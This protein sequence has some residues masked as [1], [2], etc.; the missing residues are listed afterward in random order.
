M[1]KNIEIKAR[2]SDPDQVEKIA[3]KLSGKA[4]RII[5]QEDVFFIVPKGRLKLRKFSPEEGELIFY[6][7]EN[8]IQP[9]ESHYQQSKTIDVKT[10]EEVLAKALGIRGVVRKIRKLFIVD[11]TRIHLDS[12]DHLGNFLELEVVMSPAQSLEEGVHIASSLMAKL[13]I[14]EADLIDCAYID[15]LEKG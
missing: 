14:D 10:L 12:V 7:R 1:N 11:Q 3:E 13:G 6:E 5:I 2:V 15:L 4:P 9:K 8:S